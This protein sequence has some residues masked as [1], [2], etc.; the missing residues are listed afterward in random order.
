M[1]VKA[2]AVMLALSHI[3]TI[4]LMVLWFGLGKPQSRKEFLRHFKRELLSF[5]PDAR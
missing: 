3:G 1:F 2:L 5:R 4:A